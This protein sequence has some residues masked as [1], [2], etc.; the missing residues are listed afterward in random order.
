MPGMPSCARCAFR[1]HTEQRLAYAPPRRIVGGSVLRSLAVLGLVGVLVG[2]ATTERPGRTSAPEDPRR[3]TPTASRI[4]GMGEQSFKNGRYDEAILLWR[5]ALLQ[6]P[7]P[8]AADD[9]RHKLILRIGYGQLVAHAASGDRTH[10]AN[11]QQMLLRYAVKH[12]QLF[13]DRPGAERQRG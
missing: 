4:Y 2:C 8:A 3:M 6:L 12:E 1:H 7:E 13:G 9:L 5:H 11:A 10:P